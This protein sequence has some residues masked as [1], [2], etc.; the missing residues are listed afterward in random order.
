MRLGT[1]L[2]E[3]LEKADAALAE[4]ADVTLRR[5]R[6]EFDDGGV[7]RRRPANTRRAGARPAHRGGHAGVRVPKVHEQV[8]GESGDPCRGR[9]RGRTGDPHTPGDVLDYREDVQGRPGQGLGR[10]EIGGA[11]GLCLTA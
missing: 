9:V 4:R 3:M 1:Q 6:L 7:L 11:D 8:S 5:P 2:D 10:E